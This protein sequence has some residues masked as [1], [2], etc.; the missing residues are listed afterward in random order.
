M[1]FNDT[2]KSTSA[3]IGPS[4]HIEG[5]ITGD[6]NMVIDGRV[7]GSVL[8]QNA[9]VTITKSGM[10]RADVQAKIIIVEGEVRGELRGAES[11]EVAPSG[12]VIGD[13]CSPR[14]MLQDGCQFK[15]M[16]DMDYKDSGSR[17]P[18]DRSLSVKNLPAPKP[19]SAGAAPLVAP[20]PSAS[21]AAPKLSVPNLPPKSE[22]TTK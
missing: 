8:V 4:I 3:I 12:T 22:Q 1:S 19:L 5:S 18:V 7:E 17:T 10:V 20:R 2:P 13:I 16:V 9:T 21:S 11:V 15:G 14:V 6:E